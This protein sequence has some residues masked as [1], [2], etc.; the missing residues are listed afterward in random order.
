GFGSL[1]ELLAVTIEPGVLGGGITPH[2]L[3]AGYYGHDTKELGARGVDTDG[4]L[5]V[6]DFSSMDLQVFGTKTSPQQGEVVD[7]YAE[8]LAVANSILN[9]I[10]V[11]S[12]YFAVWFVIQGFR[13]SDV[14][15]LGEHDPLVPSFKKR[16]IMVVDRSNVTKEGQ[17]PEIVLLREV[18]L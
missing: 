3:T 17:Q 11:R 12:D 10:S 15:N 5:T 2:H 6:D 16:Y 1:G 7:D 4:D 14:A 18:P 8:R 13:E 9:T